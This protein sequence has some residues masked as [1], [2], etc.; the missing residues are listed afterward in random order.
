MIYKSTYLQ[1][2]VASNNHYYSNLDSQEDDLMQEFDQYIAANQVNVINDMDEFELYLS[3]PLL[4]RSSS[5]TFDILAWWN[6]NTLKYPSVALM[7][8]DILAIPMTSVPSEAVSRILLKLV[9]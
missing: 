5:S 1:H 7:A 2:T 6:E 3:D 8:R 9:N 4:P